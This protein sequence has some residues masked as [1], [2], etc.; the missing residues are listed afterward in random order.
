MFNS[1]IKLGNEK[2]KYFHFR[3]E[4][5]NFVKSENQNLLLN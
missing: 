2:E 3:A 4:D 1:K 5:A